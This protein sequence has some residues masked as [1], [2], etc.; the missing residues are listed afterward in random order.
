MNVF[1][2]FNL[3]VHTDLEILINETL[4]CFFFIENSSETKQ[5]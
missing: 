4:K 1:F 5:K 2:F 3:F